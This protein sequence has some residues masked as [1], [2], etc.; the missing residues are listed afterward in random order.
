M[1]PHYTKKPDII[2][3]DDHLIFRQGLKAIINY[4]E[5]GSVI[6]EASNGEEF[7]QL[8]STLKPDLV[9]MDIDMPDLKII[10]FTVFSEEEYYLRMMNIGAKGFLQKSSGI[11]E[12]ENAIQLV[13]KGDSYFSTR[14]QLENC[15]AVAPGDQKESSLDKVDRNKTK[16][17]MLFFPW[18]TSK[19]NFVNI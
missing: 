4:E 12:L 19:G 5:V 7:I 17:E 16:R 9:L 11:T 3:V 2:I 13:M 15:N 18:I 8:L 10:A 14:S 6:A 1:N